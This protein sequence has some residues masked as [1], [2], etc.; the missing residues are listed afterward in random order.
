MGC[1]HS[2]KDARGSLADDQFRETR[3]CM[4]RSGLVHDHLS[5]ILLNGSRA[6]VSRFKVFFQVSLNFV[7]IRSSRATGPSSDG[8]FGVSFICDR[9]LPWFLCLEWLGDGF[10][11]SPNGKI[12]GDG[13]FFP[14]SFRRDGGEELY[15]GSFRGSLA[16]DCRESKLWARMG[17]VVVGSGLE[18]MERSWGF[19]SVGQILVG[20]AH[21]SLRS[22]LGVLWDFWWDSCFEVPCEIRWKALLNWMVRSWWWGHLSG[23]LR[24]GSLWVELEGCG[25]VW[26]EACLVDV[27]GWFKGGFGGNLRTKEQQWVFF[28]QPSLGLSFV[29]VRAILCCSRF[30]IFLFLFFILC[31]SLVVCVDQ[32]PL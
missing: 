18:W 26:S 29:I 9:K 25:V 32:C 2:I 30:W 21:C 23:W 12:L 11:F 20:S 1:R 14:S 4:V 16:G 8:V 28:T 27:G 31:W 3:L 24:R 19:F 6:K 22:T 7:F 13:V 17:R 15:C 10:L 5:I